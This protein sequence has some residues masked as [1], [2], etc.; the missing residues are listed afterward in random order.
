MTS[1]KYYPSERQFREFQ[2]RKRQAELAPAARR[3]SGGKRGMLIGAGAAVPAAVGTAL[4]AN[5]RK[6]G[7]VE[8]LFNPFAD[9][10]KADDDAPQYPRSSTGRKITASALPGAHAAVAGRRGRKVRASS[11]EYFT[12]LGGSLPGGVVSAVA[13][14]PAIRRS[15]RVTQ[16]G[17][18]IWG[19]QHGNE[20]NQ[21]KGY[22]KPEAEP[23]KKKRYEIEPG[24]SPS[25]LVENSERIDAINRHHQNRS[26]GIGLGAGT[27]LGAGLGAAVGH[28]GYKA[29]TAA[30]GA[31]TGLIGGATVGL[32]HGE[33][34]ANK[35]A[36]NA[37]LIRVAPK[38]DRNGNV[39]KRARIALPVPG[40]VPVRPST[41]S[42]GHVSHENDLLAIHHKRRRR[43]SDSALVQ[44]HS[45]A[46]SRMTGGGT[47]YGREVRKSTQQYAATFGS[48][49]TPMADLAKVGRVGHRLVLND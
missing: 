15:A 17:G 1:P 43:G 24:K 6:Q 3:L 20:I 35:Q 30:S 27:A 29:Y 14:K 22:L 36:R 41:P 11:R 44:H 49:G 45:G 21:R 4:Y 39:I 25:D 46:A 40:S 26:G 13:R 42:G 18:G 5:H 33:H 8:K 12:A 7:S 2:E 47:A 10:S 19:A 37:G 32:L 31:Y 48:R 28:K 38:R 16:I 23:F 9:I 34:A